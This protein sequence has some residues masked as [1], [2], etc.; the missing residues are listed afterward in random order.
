MMAA[1]CGGYMDPEL[2]V[3]HYTA[4]SSLSGAVATLTKPGAPLVSCHLI[5]GPEGELVQCLPFNLVGYHAGRSEWL[6]RKSCNRFS[7]GIEIVNP[8]YMRRGVKWGHGTVRAKHRN[9][10][11]E[12]EWCLYTDAQYR[13]LRM[14]LE[15]IG[16]LP[17]VGHDDVAPGRKVDPGPAF[18]WDNLLPK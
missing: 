12:R 1:E 17:V 2:V 14:V 10:G 4:G 13:T 6:G 11:P 8:G 15:A 3:L 5:V 16:P 9:G 18:V 7:I